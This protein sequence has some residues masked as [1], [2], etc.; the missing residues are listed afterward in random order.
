MEKWKEVFKEVIP[1][2]N[3]QVSLIN[4]EE[5]GLTIKLY[6]ANNLVLINFGNVRAVRM[7]DEGIVQ[8]QIYSINEL[9][10]YKQGNFKNI[11]YEIQN[12]EFENYVHEIADL[13]WDIIQSRHYVIV[14][15]NY[16][17]DI[18]AENEPTI[19]VKKITNE[20]NV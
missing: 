10:K 13:Y 5:D 19:E 1:P 3:Y 15:M 17:I 2:S 16:D 12:G 6:D 4:G 11:I 8:T 14:T 9:K 7:L 20:S 18:I